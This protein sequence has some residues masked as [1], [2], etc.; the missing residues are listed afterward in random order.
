VI[1]KRRTFIKT[2]TTDGNLEQQMKAHKRELK[3]QLDVT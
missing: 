1:E 2:Q 3:K